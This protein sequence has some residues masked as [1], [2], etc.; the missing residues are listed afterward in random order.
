MIFWLIPILVSIAISAIAYAITPKP[1]PQKPPAV[2]DL[3]EP[4]AS[5]G[6]QICVIFGEVD[7]A[8]P[9]VLWF[10]DKSTT[11]YEIDA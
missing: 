11:E 7:I 2:Q 1:K 9:N 3:K 5:A 8:D 4:T 10:G 6:K